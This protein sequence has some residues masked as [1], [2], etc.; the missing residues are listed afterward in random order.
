MKIAK[1]IILEEL[2][3]QEHPENVENVIF[4]ALEHYCKRGEGTWGEAIAYAIKERILE[5]EEKQKTK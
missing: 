5:A 2:E 4:W 1:K 3:E